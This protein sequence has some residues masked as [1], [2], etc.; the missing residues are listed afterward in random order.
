[1]YKF[2]ILLLALILPHSILTAREHLEI[3]DIES[4]QRAL[5]ERYIRFYEIADGLGLDMSGIDPH[6]TF[7]N[8]AYDGRNPGLF[9]EDCFYERDIIDEETGAVNTN[10]VVSLVADLANQLVTDWS[11]WLQPS[12][13]ARMEGKDAIDGKTA[14]LSQPVYPDTTIHAG[15]Y[16]EFFDVVTSTLDR[17]VAI[18]FQ[19]DTTD[20]AGDPN[21]TPWYRIGEASEPDCVEAM[22]E[23]LSSFLSDTPTP[24]SAPGVIIN[25]EQMQYSVY[26]ADE[27]EYETLIYSTEGT[28]F[29][30]YPAFQGSARVYGRL[31]DTSEVNHGQSSTLGL[32]SGAPHDEYDEWFLLDV[33]PMDLAGTYVSEPFAAHDEHS[34]EVQ[35]PSLAGFANG[36]FFGWGI[37]GR[38]VVSPDF[39]HHPSSALIACSDACGECRGVA[40]ACS[41]LK[42]GSIDFRMGIGRS[43][44]GDLGALQLHAQTINALSA[45]PLDLKIH[46]NHDDANVLRDGEYENVIRQ[47]VSDQ[48]LVDVEIVEPYRKYAVRHYAIDEAG[49]VVDG[50]HQPNPDEAFKSVIVENPHPPQYQA[51]AGTDLDSNPF[52]LNAPGHGIPV[53]TL[54]NAFVD[55]TGPILPEFW[56]NGPLERSEIYVLFAYD[57]DHLTMMWWDDV[58]QWWD[59]DQMVEA[60][61][62]RTLSIQSPQPF[63]TLHITESTTTHTRTIEYS[64]LAGSP[65]ADNTIT[66]SDVMENKQRNHTRER[67]FDSEDSS[68]FTDTVT[69]T[70]GNGGVIGKVEKHYRVYPWNNLGFP[71]R[72]QQAELVKEIRDPGGE[73]LTTVFDYYDDPSADG[74]N[75]GRLK[76]VEYPDGS[77]VAYEYGSDGRTAKVFRPFLDSSLSLTSGGNR[78]EEITREPVADLEGS[79]SGGIVVT[80]VESIDGQEIARRYELLWSEAFDGLARRATIEATSKGALWS[81]PNNLR[82]DRWLFAEGP[83]NGKV[84]KVKRPDRTMSFHTYTVDPESGE[85]TTTVRRGVPN[86]SEDDVI[87]GT[88]TVTVVNARGGRVS[89]VA[90]D[91]ASGIV[92]DS[93]ITMPGDFDELGRPLVTL[94]HDGTFETREY[95]DCCGI[96]TITD[97]TGATRTEFTEMDGTLT[98]VEDNGITTSYL[99]SHESNGPDGV[100][101]FTR[102]TVVTGRNAAGSI[103][104]GIDTFDPAGR[105]IASLDPR[106]KV[107]RL[108][109]HL[110]ELD[111]NG[112]HIRTTVLP[113]GAEA[114]DVFHRDGSPR[115]HTFEGVDVIRF[116]Y[117]VEP[118]THAVF[119]GNGFVSQSFNARTVTEI[120]VGTNGEES[121]WQKSYLDML[122]RVYKVEIPDEHGNAVGNATLTFYDRRGSPRKEVDPDGVATVFQYD[123]RGR[124]EYSV[125][126]LNKNDRID[127]GGADRITEYSTVVLNDAARGDVVRT[128]T[129]VWETD[130]AD[131]ATVVATT[132]RSTDRLNVWTTTRGQLVHEETIC[133]GAGEV[134]HRSTMPDDTMHASVVVNG[135]VT[136]ETVTHPT[137]GVLSAFSH[138]PDGFDRRIQTTDNLL[139]G[140]TSFQYY[141]SG[142]LREV[143]TPESAPGEGD[144]QTTEYFYDM[145]DQLVSTRLPNNDTSERRY[146]PDGSLKRVFGRNTTPVEYTYDRQGRMRTMTTWQEF[147][148]SAPDGA[149]AGGDAVTTW[150]YNALG[151]LAAKEDPTGQEVTYSYTPGGRLRFRDWARLGSDETN[152]VRTVYGYGA[153]GA[154]DT[155]VISGDLRGVFYQNDP[156]ETPEIR[157]TYDRLGRTATVE[158]ASGKRE[159]TYDDGLLKNEAYVTG[160]PD[161]FTGLTIERGHDARNRLNAIDVEFQHELLYQADYT[162][163]AT[164]RLEM[165]RFHGHQVT[166]GHFPAAEVRQTLTYNNGQSSVLSVSRNFDNLH[167]LTARES[168]VTDGSNYTYSYR[169]NNLNQRD[170]M[171]L[172]DDGYWDFGYDDLGQVTAGGKFTSG[173]AP[174]DGFAYGYSFDHIGNRTEATVNGR[175]ASYTANLLN[176]YENRDVPRAIDVLGTAHPDASV[177][178]NGEAATRNNEL[179]Y[180]I[181]DLS[182]IPDANEPQWL[183]FTVTGTLS[184][185]GH[186]D[187]DRIAEET[188]TAFL[189]SNPELFAHDADGNL[190]R[191]GRWKYTWN[192]ENRLVRMETLPSAVTVGA[193]NL[194]LQFA[195]DSQG[196]RFRKTIE[197]NDSGDWTV[198][199]DR[200]FVYEGWNLLLELAPDTPIVTQSY[201]WGLDL[202]GTLQGAGGV[203]GLLMIEVEDEIHY[204]VYDGNGNIMALIDANTA[205]ESARYE[206]GPFGEPL[207]TTGPMANQNP[208]RFSTKYTDNETGLLYY[209]FRYYDPVTGRW[210]NRDPIEERGGLNLYAFVG[211]DPVNRWDYLG[212]QWWWP[213]SWFGGDDNTIDGEEIISS[214][215]FAS[216][217]PWFAEWNETERID[218]DVYVVDFE[219]EV[220]GK[221]EYKDC[222]TGEIEEAEDSLYY[223]GNIEGAYGADPLYTRVEARGFI[224]LTRYNLIGLVAS[225]LMPQPPVQM[226]RADQ[227]YVFARL[228]REVPA[229]PSEWHWREIEFSGCE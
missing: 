14:V 210:L 152:P 99:E 74:P 30:E 169:Y 60:D 134:I 224:P 92:L 219:I 79:G 85:K 47:I 110:E 160:A 170:R 115:S 87:D 39:Q 187:A 86:G 27:D 112:R 116:E 96:V 197:E 208:F 162:Y 195:Y 64:S 186:N 172:E 77:W 88:E 129:R 178:V 183:D 103:T 192:A 221:T 58:N 141:D 62:S 13:H 82:T 182:N 20:L 50:F 142:H 26:D 213:P 200:L 177:T 111:T 9:P 46:L 37:A 191:D 31:Y 181:L 193:P 146:H 83:F 4:A 157:Y 199:D 127:F 29:V 80:R 91:I 69:E 19:V 201:L 150:T 185:G 73:A 12:W 76:S 153:G 196:R 55:S 190:L 59:F 138:Q 147:D 95:E 11:R 34:F 18:H 133:E 132:D 155:N 149:G 48:V 43:A 45:S 121:E 54:F 136:S 113:N 209:G 100:T 104:T 25:L 6:I 131:V 198:V 135:F 223:G 10:V 175:Q 109:R 119:D 1:M 35:C 222:C 63:G 36:E 123:D 139:G 205:T 78:V 145:V 124:L 56:V 184:G 72:R 225:L 97:R 15:N 156:A 61:D 84:A 161:L 49:A 2:P 114:V 207:R 38:L 32:P 89:R 228:S 204:P 120:R 5:Q 33:F 189:P 17:M 163:D 52:F 140:T 108:T 66:M 165:A 171:T 81:D 227:R 148:T 194:R 144:A 7:P 202:S 21:G 180:G 93:A 218:L 71:T 101:G 168:I 179:F 173:D 167:R 143:T 75:F 217:E 44:E 214:R 28:F 130:G 174:I 68:L 67:V 215:E 3:P 24:Q 41:E 98:A 188:R 118:D 212:L 51:T 164:S 216:D 102:S 137:E 42:F 106:D 226:S 206:Y 53:G 122:G 70:D 90:S 154:G 22:D 126:D 211:N 128:E 57:P 159:M 16:L 8:R 125:L 117:G 166:Y 107:D 229:A 176:Q 151:L 40:G 158:D 105:L 65:A 220:E 94:F 23:A 203:G